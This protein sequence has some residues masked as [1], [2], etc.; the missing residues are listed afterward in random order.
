MKAMAEKTKMKKSLLIHTV[1]AYTTI[2]P[3]KM[4]SAPENKVSR[5][6]NS[7]K[8]PGNIRLN[9]G[10]TFQYWSD[11][12]DLTDLKPDIELAL[13]LEKHYFAWYLLV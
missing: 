5:K 12:R 3:K 2:Q 8:T 1:T 7:P 9:I 13:L 6:K 11:L 10:V 4:K